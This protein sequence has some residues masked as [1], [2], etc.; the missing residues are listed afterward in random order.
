IAGLGCNLDPKAALVKCLLEICQTHPG[1]VRRFKDSPPEKRLNRY[2]D[3]LTLMDHSAFLTMPER[4]D[5]FS[6]LLS[7]GRRQSLETLPSFSTGDV[8]QDLGTCVNTLV[9]AGCRVAYADLTT[10]DIIVVGMIGVRRVD[11]E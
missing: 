11:T 6:F 10:A 1:E 2:R 7:N 3:V 5:E 9:K 4:L 8:K